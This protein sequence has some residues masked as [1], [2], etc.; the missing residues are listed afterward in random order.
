MLPL[1]YVMGPSGA[2]KDTLIAY[3][4]A[5]V[6]PA[7]I[8]FAHR[9]ITRPATEGG[10]NHIALTVD[11]FAKRSAAGLFALSWYSHGFA[12]A[13]GVEI[14]LLRAHVAL[15]VV[16]G[17]RAAWPQAQRR[18]PDL[19]GV[20]IE[21]PAAVRAERLTGRGREDAAAIDE[22]LAAEVKVAE[23]ESVHRLDNGGA[24]Q[25]AGDELV[26]F[27]ERVAHDK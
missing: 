6:D 9:Y 19:R 4:R 12:Y 5:R 20:L 18:Y 11:E 17:S 26:A 7:R 8:V 24:L 25:H 13:I 15:I 14:D 1:V 10:E 16:S 21:A 3:A 2:G 27:H 23:S 22:R